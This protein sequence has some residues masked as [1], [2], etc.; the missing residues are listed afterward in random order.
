MSNEEIKK[1]IDNEYSATFEV[2]GIRYDDPVYLT[3][4]RCAEFGY[5]LASEELKAL[6]EDNERVMKLL[7]YYFKR[8]NW[9]EGEERREISWQQFKTKNNFK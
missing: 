6:R 9:V 4:R 5:S 7:E 2:I 1:K 8:A 3:K